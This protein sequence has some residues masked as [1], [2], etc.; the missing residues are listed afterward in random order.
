[1]ITLLV[2]TLSGFRWRTICSTLFPNRT[3]SST[4]FQNNFLFDSLIYN[5]TL[6]STVFHK[7]TFCST[8][9]HN[10]L[11]SSTVF[12]NRT[13]CSAVFHNRTFCL[14]V[15]FFV[16]QVLGANDT[17]N[18]SAQD[19]PDSIIAGM[20]VLEVW[21]AKQV[22]THLILINRLIFRLN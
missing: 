10:R 16:E 2:M 5:L 1:M 17:V 18:C 14:T 9:F 22:C 19:D 15:T 13:F 12:P 4:F 11:F 21:K 3:F 20:P 7:I 8:V 6:S